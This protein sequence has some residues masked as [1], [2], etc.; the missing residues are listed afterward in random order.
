MPDLQSEL[1][2]VLSQALQGA[3]FDDDAGSHAP[4]T[5]IE[6]SG[7]DESVTNSTRYR[8]WQWVKENPNSTITE[9]EVALGRIAG[10]DGTKLNLSAQVTAML[11]RG[12]L[13]RSKNSYGVYCYR[14]VGETY[15]YM[16]VPERL[17][18]AREAKAVIDS[19]RATRSDAGKTRRPYKKRIAVKPAVAVQP[20][21]AAPAAPVA[22]FFDVD[23]IISNL[24]VLQAKQLLTKLKEVFGV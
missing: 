8:F 14:A 21:A 6:S 22:K 3:D 24:N 20:K 4:A 15:K 19:K 13:E 11:K 10:V 23:E 16:T 5:V 7:L 18:M 2:K 17:K 9:A 1:N 12:V